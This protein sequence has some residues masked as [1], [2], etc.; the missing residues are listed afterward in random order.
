[1]DAAA[2]LALV[3]EGGQRVALG[4]VEDGGSAGEAVGIE[5]LVQLLELIRDGRTVAELM[6]L[7]R[8]MLGR[9]Q[10]MAGV[11]ELIAEVFGGS[12]SEARRLLAQGGVKLDGEPL[13]PEALD[14]AADRLDGAVL[15]VGKRRFKRLRRA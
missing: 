5:L 1:M 14:V 7:G 13:A 12:R 2:E 15:Q 11:P 4:G 9:A 10:V 8:R 6:D 3:P